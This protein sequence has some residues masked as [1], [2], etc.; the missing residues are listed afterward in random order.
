M[1]NNKTVLLIGISGVYNYGCEAIVRGT[2]NYLKHK[3]NNCNVVYASRN[4]EDDIKRLKGCDIKII[5]RPFKKWSIKN[6]FRK[7]MSYFNMELEFQ[8]EDLSLLDG[9]DEVYSIG[10]DIYTLD[11]L[12]KC[13]KS[14]PLFGEACIKRGIPYVLWGCSIGPFTENP[15]LEKFFI[16]HLNKVSEIVTREQKTMDYIKSINIKTPI[17]LFPDPAFLVERTL[18]RNEV[19][20]KINQIGIN[21]SPLSA[22][23]YGMSIDDA[24]SENVKFITGLIDKLSCKVVLIPHVVYDDLYNGDNVFINKVYDSIPENYKG[25]IREVDSDPGFI[26]VKEEIVKCDVVIAARMHCA[27]NTI[28]CNVPIVFLAYSSKAIGMSQFLY[29]SSEFVID[30]SMINNVDIV[31]ILSKVKGHDFSR[32]L[33]QIDIKKDEK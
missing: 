19:A 6:I 27:I 26:G 8:I 31:K 29:G 15:K 32:F 18:V 14:F 25:Y 17:R 12:N 24:V 10:G 20:T 23:Y 5:N 13:S 9:V 33:E 21:I 30:M 2:V 22:L 7:L 4:V 11:H 16:K 3:Y 28:T 1:K